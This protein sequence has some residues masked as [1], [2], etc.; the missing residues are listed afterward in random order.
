M[1]LN[2][3]HTHG[4][5]SLCALLIKS[6]IDL[7]YVAYTM[8]SIAAQ[9]LACLVP[10]GTPGLDLDTVH[11]SLGSSA[12]RIQRAESSSKVNSSEMRKDLLV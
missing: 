8:L 3:K 5:N 1:L 12:F 9:V 6:S 11:P 10:V 2:N 4:D 7:E